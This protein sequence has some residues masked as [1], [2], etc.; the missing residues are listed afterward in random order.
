MRGLF[1][2]YYFDARS[3]IHRY[4]FTPILRHTI[5][6]ETGHEIAVKVLRSGLAPRDLV[7]N[8]D[9]LRTEVEQASWY[10][11]PCTHRCCASD[12]YLVPVGLAAGFDKHGEAIDGA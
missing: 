9:I 10:L 6:A 7:K 11:S 8:D 2:A 1:A 12:R 4:V 5:D 3:A